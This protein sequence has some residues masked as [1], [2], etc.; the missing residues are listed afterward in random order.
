[1]GG[2]A[3]DATDLDVEVNHVEREV[4]LLNVEMNHVG[5]ALILTRVGLLRA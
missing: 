5:V 1:M 4:N 2:V 3:G